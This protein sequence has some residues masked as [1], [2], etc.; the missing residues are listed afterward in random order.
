M[1]KFSIWIRHLK[2]YLRTALQDYW[3]TDGLHIAINKVL[4]LGKIISHFVNIIF[5]FILKLKFL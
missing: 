2:K 1:L 4:C 3:D 5:N